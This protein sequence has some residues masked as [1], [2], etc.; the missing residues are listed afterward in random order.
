MRQWN[1]YDFRIPLWSTHKYG[2][3]PFC[4]VDWK[5]NCS[6]IRSSCCGWRIRNP[7]RRSSGNRLRAGADCWNIPPSFH[8]NSCGRLRRWFRACSVRNRSYIPDNRFWCKCIIFIVQNPCMASAVRASPRTIRAGTVV[9][10]HIS[11]QILNIMALIALI[12]LLMTS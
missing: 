10:I 1:S 6:T 3:M 2:R 8:R 5:K 12:I 11:P 7:N 4:Y 9:F